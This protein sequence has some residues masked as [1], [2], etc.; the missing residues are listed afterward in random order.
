M[1]KTLVMMLLC[2]ISIGNRAENINWNNGWQQYHEP[3]VLSKDVLNGYYSVS[4]NDST[5]FNIYIDITAHEDTICELMID[6]SDIYGNPKVFYFFEEKATYFFNVYRINETERFSI[7][8]FEYNENNDFT[9]GFNV[10]GLGQNK[11]ATQV[12]LELLNGQAIK[13]VAP[14]NS[15]KYQEIKEL[16]IPSIK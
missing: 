7:I 15:A 16:T 4:L 10:N 2:F 12:A 11:L 8:K 1:K 6:A 9:T 5:K 14:T 13:L 3:T